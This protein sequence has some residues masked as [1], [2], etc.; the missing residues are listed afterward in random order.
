MLCHVCGML[1]VNDQLLLIENVVAVV[2]FLY[3][4]ISGLLPYKCKMC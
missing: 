4:Y 3:S 2:G 1:H